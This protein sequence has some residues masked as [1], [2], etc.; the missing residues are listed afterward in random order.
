MT[1]RGL[2]TR[3]RQAPSV[4]PALSV[5]ALCI[6]MSLARAELPV[7]A[8]LPV[9]CAAGCGPTGTW[10]SSGSVDSPYVLGN[11]M[12]I[13]QRSDKA[14][15]N[16]ASFDIAADHGVEF[17][18]LATDSVVLNRIYQG[19]SRIEGVLKANGQVYLINQ[20]G[21]VF[22]NGAQVD[23]H[24]LL[25]TSLNLT[26]AV[27]EKGIATAI[28]NV[29]DKFALG[30]FTGEVSG[31]ITVEEDA[32]LNAATGGK[33][34]LFAPQV[35]NGGV[36]TTHDGQVI[37]AAG[38]KIYLQPS[39]DQNVR[40]LWVEVDS[41]NAQALAQVINTGTIQAERGNVT[42]MGL[43]VNQSGRVTA[44]SSVALNGSIRLLA[45][46]DAQTLES[47]PIHLSRKVMGQVTGD[48]L[49]GAGSVTEVLP[50]LDDTDTSVGSAVFD[51]NGELLNPSIVEVMG[52]NILME[53]DSLIHAPAGTVTLAAVENP[54]T[55]YNTKEQTLLNPDA[56]N[57]SIVLEAGS[58]IDVAG[59]DT[60]LAMER[61][62]LEIF[63]TANDLADAPLQRDGT[64]YR[65]TV[66]VDAREG[67]PLFDV[68]DYV[69]NLPV[70]IGEKS[71]V[72]GKVTLQSEGTVNVQAGASVD[73]SGGQVNFDDGFI[74]TTKLI[75]EGEIVDIGAADPDR[76]YSSIV[77][78][79]SE[80]H[81]KWA[82]TETWSSGLATR[83]EFVQGYS[84]GQDAG[85]AA[86]AG[87]VLNIDGD[88]QGHATRG[89]WQ[90]TA[91]E[92]PKGGRLIV[93][94]SVYESEKLKSNLAPAVSFDVP[95]PVADPLAAPVPELVL[96]TEMLEQGGFNRLAVYSDGA[97]R[98][99]EE[100]QLD[101]SAG[102]EAT[103]VGQTLDIQGDVTIP[104]GA[105]DLQTVQFDQEAEG[106]KHTLTV[107]A[108]AQLDVRGQWVNDLLVVNSPSSSAMIGGGS[109][110]ARS[111]DDLTLE[112]GSVLDVSGGGWI[113]SDGKGTWGKAG[114]IDLAAH[115]GREV[116]VPP[117]GVL[118]LGAELRAYSLTEGG[119][120]S[121][122]ANSIL[123]QDPAAPEVNSTEIAV[124]TLALTPGFFAQGGFRQFDLTANQGELRVAEGTQLD[125]VARNL[126]FDGRD[127]RAQPSGAN[128]DDFTHVTVL[129]A[130]LRKPVDL[131]L[132]LQPKSAT[133]L[134]QTG[135]LSIGMDA[136]IGT[137]PGGSIALT[138]GTRILVE[139]M[140]Q[141]EAGRVAMTLQRPEII[142]IPNIGYLPDQTIWLG[143][144][145]TVDV[146]G[147]TVL[148]PNADGLRLGKVYDGGEVTL[149]ASARGFVV[150]EEGAVVDASGT[151]ATLDLPQDQLRREPVEVASAGGSIS[152]KAAEGMLLDGTLLAQSGGADVAGGSLTV[153]YS[154]ETRDYFPVFSPTI[155]LA[156]ETIESGF[157]QQ[158]G[159][160]VPELLGKAA[161][162]AASIND[163]GFDHVALTST[164]S[165]TLDAGTNLDTRGSITLD[166]PSIAVTG[167]G[168][169]QVH[170]AY[171]ALGNSDQ[172]TQLIQR[173]AQSGSGQLRVDA[174]S[175]L[176]LTGAFLIDNTD[177]VQL[178][179][180]GDLRLRGVVNTNEKQLLGSLKTQADVTLSAD[181]IYPTTLTQYEIATP[182]S[183]T[184]LP[185]GATAPVYSAGGS[186][187]LRAAEIYQSGVLKA[188]L[189][190]IV[191]DAT[192]SLTLTTG[193]VTDVS[194]H[195]AVIPFGALSS[196]L[197]WVYP[198]PGVASTNII[199]NAPEK[200]ITLQGPDI[201]VQN[202]AVL[203]MSGGGEVLAHEFVP[204]TGGSV[205]ILANNSERE[206]Y[207]VLPDL[208]GEFAPYDPHLYTG[209]SLQPGDSVYLSGLG[210]LPAR[211]YALLPA[212]YALLPGA[213]LVEAVSGYGDLPLN[214]TLAQRDG[215]SVVSGY[216]TSAGGAAREMR[217]QG[218]NVRKGPE[219]FSGLTGT[220]FVQL[221]EY[222]QQ[223]AGDFFPAWTA[224]KEQALGRLPQ[225]A[226]TLVLDVGQSLVLEGTLRAA[227][228][229]DGRGAAVDIAADRLALVDATLG[230]AAPEDFVAVDV[231]SLNGLGAESLLLGGR[232]S[233]G[234]EGTHIDVT[235]QEVR[236]EQNVNLTAPD[237]ILA[238]TEKVKVADNAHLTGSGEIDTGDAVFEVD[239]DGALLR[240]SA[241]PQARINR[242]YADG[243]AKGQ[244][245]VLN[246]G[247]G[248]V[249]EAD[250]SMILDAA[251]D[252]TF[253]GEI[254]MAE[255]SL[256]IGASHVSIGDAP[257]ATTGFVLN[258]QTLAAFQA[259]ELVLTSRDAVDVYGPVQ[260]QAERLVVEA[261]GLHGHDMTDG[262]TATITADHLELANRNNATATQ[263][264]T[265]SGGTLQ[266]DA[267]DLVIGGGEF[268]IEGYNQVNMQASREIRGIDK[269]ALTAAAPT[270][271]DAGRVSVADGGELSITAV[272]NGADKTYHEIAV[273]RSQP[274]YDPV[275]TA[276]DLGG[277]L[278]LTGS[279]IEHG[280]RIELPSGEVTLQAMG[281][282][283][284]DGVHLLDGSEIL[285]S[286]SARTF[287]DSTVYAPAGS[288]KLAAANG[289]VVMDEGSRLDLS[290]ASGGGDA[291]TLIVDTPNGTALLD[292]DIDA[293]AGANAAGGSVEMDIGAL[294]QYRD[295]DALNRVL[296]DA[297][298]SAKQHLRIRNGDVAIGADAEVTA[299]DYRLVA[300]AGNIDLHGAIDASGARGGRVELWAGD[301]VTLHEMASINATAQEAEGR[302][303]RVVLAAGDDGQLSLMEGAR[304]DVSGAGAQLDDGSI[305]VVDNGKVL[306]R[307]PRTADGAAIGDF[308]AT[309]DGTSEV[310]VEAVK[311]T[312]VAAGAQI[313]VAMIDAL[314]VE[315]QTFMDAV[316]NGN[317]PAQLQTQLTQASGAD[318]QL[319]LRSG[320]EIRGDGDLTLA[321]DWDLSTW[322][323]GAS[324][325]PGVLTIRA[326]GDLLVNE[327]LSDGFDGASH[328][329][330]IFG[331]KPDAW[332]YR[333][334][335]GAD[336]G[337]AYALA[338]AD[339]IAAGDVKIA[340]GTKAAVVGNVPVE[341]KMLRTTTGD[342]EV[343]AA[344]DVVLGNQESVIYT[345]GQP[346]ARRTGTAGNTAVYA[347]GGG[348]VRIR[349]G[350]DVRMDNIADA[351]H[352]DQLIT[353]WL[354][355]EGGV[356][357]NRTSVITVP[358]NWWI[359]YKFFQ[360]GIGVLGG[361][362]ASVD[363][364]GNIE[365]VSVVLPTVKLPESLE[366][367]NGGQ[368]AVHAGGDILGGVF[369]LGKGEA[370]IRAG[371]TLGYKRDKLYGL[372]TESN[373]V[374]PILALG[375]GQMRVS[376][377]ADMTLQGVINPT[378][379][380]P[381][382]QQI[383]FGGYSA[384]E[385]LVKSPSYFFS[386]GADSGVDMVSLAGDVNMS[387]NDQV[388]IDRTLLVTPPTTPIDPVT[389]A[390]S[391][392]LTQVLPPNVRIVSLQGNIAIANGN[393]STRDIYQYPL[394]QTDL[395]FLAKGDIGFGGTHIRVPDN[396]E[397]LPTLATPLTIVGRKGNVSDTVFLPA[398]KHA[399]IPI[400][401]SGD[402]PDLTP[403]RIVAQDGDINGGKF[404][405][406]KSA[407][408]EA[409]RDIGILGLQAQNLSDDD[410]TSIVAGRDVTLI[411][412]ESRD[413]TINDD[414]IEVLG[415]GRLYVQA[416]RDVSLGNSYGLVTSGNLKN[417]ALPD[418]GASITVL[419]GY[420]G[421]ISQAPISAL[422]E[423]YRQEASSEL[424]AL[425]QS[426]RVARQTPG[427]TEEQVLQALEN[428][429]RAYALDLFF[430]ELK[431]AGREKDYERSAELLQQFFPLS[432]GE[433]YNDGDILLFLSQIRTQSGG[434][435]DLL[436]LGGGVNA[437]LA[438]PPSGTTKEPSDLG[439]VA[440]SLGRVRAYVDE[441]FIVNQSRVFTLSG[442][443]VL[444]WSENGDIDAG[445]GKKSVL[446]APPPT[447]TVD[448]AG[449]VTANLPTAAEGSGIR[450]IKTSSSDM[451]GD[452]DLV[453][454]K[455][456]VIAGEAGIRSAGNLYV[457]AV[458]V[459][460]GDDIKAGGVSV[461][462]PTQATT[463][464]A[465]SLAGAGTDTNAAGNGIDDGIGDAAKDALSDTPLADAALSFLEVEVLGFGLDSKPE[466]GDAEQEKEKEQQ[467][468]AQ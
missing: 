278:T 7:R 86:I 179:S 128:L 445:K 222:S 343:D 149:D 240:V 244:R 96:S 62:Q 420:N 333:I 236:V 183:I 281:G 238:A 293:Q 443:D 412:K 449:N 243:E 338:V 457:A 438:V 330:K 385:K 400:P 429:P 260:V 363:A 265:Q 67:T 290:G 145:S 375:D 255:G 248:A 318:V 237:I 306:L 28:Y 199:E 211:R 339:D 336:L 403:V 107:G 307:A 213:Y 4:A 130:E 219:S 251:Q 223:R 139:G 326:A 354:H 448:T 415:P 352:P 185:G 14:I 119:K 162:S 351:N 425:T 317:Q 93:G 421:E 344:G 81:E 282:E 52:R 153:E 158:P 171:V 422:L 414:G 450:I 439:I 467:P 308:N 419:A 304:I 341:T 452:M 305:P 275:E 327:T 217:T 143:S 54:L 181:Q 94:Q 289:D 426:L 57:T 348:D 115:Q 349:A 365:N 384:T 201:D 48:V 178:H 241:A 380:E 215:S 42:L 173:D 40:G 197:N 168:E 394:P 386:Y 322:R 112:A 300:D 121:L 30:P 182:G 161:L 39:N 122:E 288:V 440:Q 21:I 140:L 424:A 387:L 85:T 10:V 134:A 235:A 254:R 18:Q 82:V 464:M 152:V 234:E 113:A 369:Y 157:A 126:E 2:Q 25:A 411:Y 455:G 45:R 22:G 280:G 350:G 216:F 270:L 136:R 6:S 78:Q 97:I 458:R 247:A 87:H 102:G 187:T 258:K 135:S 374:Y 71:A 109:I 23:V 26:D 436:A 207:A 212:A 65:Q 399:S 366:V 34:M 373:P 261:A 371:E 446:S 284:G 353:A 63:V 224:D 60:T 460:G 397:Y 388:L 69:A 466:N 59:V 120:L 329:A 287:A 79:H 320:V 283:S 242:R 36:I 151:V 303:G 190:E 413:V 268:G 170:S 75:S 383:D 428:D 405:L 127:Y 454:P 432:E 335:A 444:L 364:G 396:T 116:P 319:R 434:D 346:V 225:D 20:N 51:D 88:L 292:G 141:A 138:S 391:S 381:S 277:E 64:L 409:G 362:D 435:I 89:E 92:V 407:T 441:D 74:K 210:D 110:N 49:L 41:T 3:K 198:L 395:Q 233:T 221:G 337:S 188:P 431:L 267:Q 392:V 91:D 166:A 347:T 154:R 342:I 103:L 195:D 442:G 379:V 404:Y 398:N 291:G 360:Q 461:G 192:D 301:N 208:G 358:A 430:N 453:A 142:D 32:T 35:A 167:E 389:D 155:T 239:G 148:I 294:A 189:G 83:G 382:R 99:P 156:Q 245:S 271:L 465:S 56:T 390:G 253:D 84:E 47:N 272:T 246:I 393:N 174:D 310:V 209:S 194:A 17:H 111:A 355:R 163:G 186:M 228:Q 164:G 131:S 340:P 118:E 416:G 408:F 1:L 206:F 309:I 378:V 175:L 53:S 50:Q 226:G 315:T 427:L 5:L 296:S 314:K 19:D 106:T 266:L 205:D 402:E 114:T 297:G 376:S 77:G 147:T 401:L 372:E 46:S 193:S 285:V 229:G 311:A 70:T 176:D 321:A 418:A 345:A 410:V 276:A 37:L 456:E 230:A 169:A 328:T 200:R 313:D 160:E 377:G 232:R 359:N 124:N 144:E 370:D 150:V 33:I 55:D 132:T 459:V 259:K 58:R 316:S 231:A 204:G 11:T 256:N 90:R 279:R 16:W 68:S 357:N 125:L 24:T 433:H 447:Y 95:A 299:E 165:I 146:Q 43:A 437:G 214:T 264:P 100:S 73:V 38:D 273:T 334:A 295:Y 66:Y 463:S 177:E 108:D 218:F 196:G 133:S 180:D 117:Q 80:R 61:N 72:G 417:G 312:Q 423:T 101:F 227:P 159:A 76:V 331:D 367:M 323:F 9:P 451:A 286:G 104:S 44:T 332:S 184:V 27:F 15:L 462:V 123:I 252:M 137:D 13:E 12:H 406:S 356:F 249:L 274:S 129:P 220:G 172:K 324:D 31:D 29:S 269:G 262:T 298:F 191:L 203:D 368:L 250:Q 468:E 105:I 302:G 98:L 325:E 202:G 263:N 257:E 361:G 8:P